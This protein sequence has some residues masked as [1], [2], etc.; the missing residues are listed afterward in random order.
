MTAC[1]RRWNHNIHYYPVVLDA[2]PDGCTRA[3]EIGCGEGILAATLSR[4][5]PDVLAIDLDRPSI[6]LARRQNPASNIQFLLGDF[7]SFPF[8][9]ASFDFVVCVAALHHMSAMAAIKRMRELLRP[10]GTLA[11]VG[12]VRSRY[13]ADLPR[14]FLATVANLAHRVRKGHWAS[15]APLSP[16]PETYAEL[17]SIAQQLLPGVRIRRRLLWRYT[18]TWTEGQVT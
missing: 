13:P 8:E 17:R 4:S 16:P 6:E 5:V 2:L 15:S 7:L 14:D 9:P 12:L 1:R 11:V 18:L 3:L 10:G